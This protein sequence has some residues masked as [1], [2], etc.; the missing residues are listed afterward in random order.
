MKVNL[1]FDPSVS[2]HILE[3]IHHVYSFTNMSH[4][5][6]IFVV[7]LDFNDRKSLFEWEQR[8]N[9]EFVFLTTDETKKY[10]SKNLFLSAYYKTILIRKYALAYN[11]DNIF[12]NYFIDAL[13]FLPFFL[14]RRMNLSGIVYRIFLYKKDKGIKRFCEK[15]LYG[16]ITKLSAIKRI[17]L[18]NDN[19]ATALF[20]EMF[21]TDKFY[22]LPDPTPTVDMS[23]LVNL[24]QEYDIAVSDVVYF[25]FGIDTRKHSLDILNAIDLLTEEETRGRVFVFARYV[26]KRIEETFRQKVKQM[27]SRHRIIVIDKYLSYQEL[28]NWVYTCDVIFA[29]YSNVCQSSG[30]IGYGAC[31]HKPIIGAKDGLLGFLIRENKLGITVFPKPKDIRDAILCDIVPITNNYAET[32]SI[33]NFAQ[34]IIHGLKVK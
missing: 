14:P 10:Y 24:R 20:N 1:F 25:Q 6:F 4:D 11:A 23:K 5:K 26:D 29:T 34:T 28:Y 3:Y 21:N 9:V 17:Y 33:E 27:G 12:L 22:Y 18:L 13:P 19:N 32:H 8:D 15:I 30:T 7:G 2:G 16:L 31:F